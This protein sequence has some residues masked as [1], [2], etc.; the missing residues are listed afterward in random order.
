[1]ENNNLEPVEQFRTGYVNMWWDTPA[2]FPMIGKVFSPERQAAKEKEMDAFI[3]RMISE[4]RQFPADSG[5]D[6][7]EW[8][9]RVRGLIR[10]TGNKIMEFT[11]GCMDLLLNGGFSRV[12]S[13]FI[14][15]AREF[16][17]SVEMEDIMQAMRNVWIMN[18]IQILLGQD[19]EF[20]SSLFAYSM[21]YPYTDN[22]LDSPEISIENKKKIGA[23]F[24]MKLEGLPVDAE[25]QY[26]SALFKLVGMIEEQYPRNRYSRV[27]ASLLGI[28]NAQQKS[29]LQQYGNVS[30]YEADVLGISMEKGGASVLTDAYL[31]KGLLTE[32]EAVF[33]F[34]FGVFLQLIDDAQDAA[35]DLKNGH[36]TIFSQT[37]GKWP[38][39]NITNRL[40][41]FTYRILDSNNCFC[42]PDMKELIN[43]IKNNC[44][45]LLFGAIAHNT[46]LYG[47]SYIER[48]EK[49]SPFSF[50]YIRQLSKKIGKE[51]GRLNKRQAERPMDSMIARALAQN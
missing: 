2:T 37:A 42:T 11:D 13:D 49:H 16:D 40:F 48:M 45:F 31:A 10:S 28:H 22:Y 24:R 25:N 47:K 23:K 51:Y 46:E 34:G 7:R 8:G 35:A 5:G 39:D 20:T 29:L 50:K 38:L 9:S 33:M 12:T 3:N 18:S 41:N 15:K 21:L 6:C 43:V 26:E 27:Y 44:A 14:N 30:P 36:M 19:V 32:A 1:M 4:I 17:P